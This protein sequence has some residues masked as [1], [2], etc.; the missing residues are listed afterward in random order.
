MTADATEGDSGCASDH[1]NSNPSRKCN[2]NVTRRPRF[3]GEER[4]CS[5][6]ELGVSDLSVP[7]E[8]RTWEVVNPSGS[9]L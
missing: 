4:R 9:R 8:L 1:P 5:Q 2:E 3:E 7:P 6:A